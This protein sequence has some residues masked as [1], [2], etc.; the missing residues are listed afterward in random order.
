VLTLVV[1]TPARARA[2]FR[3]LD[4]LTD[5]A[6]LVTSEVVPA[7]RATGPALDRG[8]LTLARLDLDAE[9]R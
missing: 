3:I 8:G 5:E 2:W 1:D 6:G 9:F 7:F 4:R